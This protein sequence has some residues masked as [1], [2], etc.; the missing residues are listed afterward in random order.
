MHITP[1]IF[2][3][4]T[5]ELSVFVDGCDVT[6][7]IKAHAGVQ[8]GRFGRLVGWTRDAFAFGL[9]GEDSNL[10]VVVLDGHLN[11]KEAAVR[12]S[13]LGINP[14]GEILALHLP[15]CAP[16]ALYQVHLENRNRL[17]LIDEAGPLFYLARAGDTAP[18]N[19]ADDAV[20]DQGV[21]N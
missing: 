12:A 19:V 10:G 2:V 18:L 5:P 21:P 3:Q 14:G 13:Q 9:D 8:L 7:S 15:A 17:M 6:R 20:L 16:Q 1:N 11:A 4:L